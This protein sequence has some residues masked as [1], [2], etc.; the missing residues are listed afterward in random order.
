VRK[1]PEARKYRI[2]NIFTNSFLSL[3]ARES[4]EQIYPVS[5]S[6][7]EELTEIS[8]I[9]RKY[10]KNRN[11]WFPPSVLQLAVINHSASFQGT[12]YQA[13]LELFGQI[14]VTREFLPNIVS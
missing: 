9:L 4:A 5:M 6:I 1:Q 3:I 10:P 7:G 12:V 8:G 11:F 14:D 13:S 2:Y